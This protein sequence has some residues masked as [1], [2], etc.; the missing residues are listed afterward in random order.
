ME[1]FGAAF[2]GHPRLHRA[3]TA[4]ALRK[5]AREVRDPEVRRALTP[6]HALGCKRPTVSDD[7]YPAFNRDNV[8]LATSP[9]AAAEREG[10]RTGDGVLHRLDHI[11]FA[12]GFTVADPDGLLKVVGAEGQVLPQEWARTGAQAHRGVTVAGYPNLVM[13]L[14]PNSGLSYSSVLHVA[15]SQMRYVLQYLDARDR[16]GPGAALDVR[17]QAQAAYNADVQARLAGSVWASGCRSWYLDRAGV[18]RVIYPGTAQG[19]RRA[20]RR[21]DAE[22]YAVRLPAGSACA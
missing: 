12:T 9:I 1:A 19:Y 15:E 7:F 20:M 14:G 16:A 3:V 5:L 8:E 22:A 2:F 13:L 21:F 18:N 17:P 10:L 11:V 4:V 6:D